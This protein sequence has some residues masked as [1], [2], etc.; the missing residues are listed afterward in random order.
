LCATPVGKMDK[1][2]GRPKRPRRSTRRVV[3]CRSN[4]KDL[5]LLLI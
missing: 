5:L 4:T 2:Q 3:A 1:M